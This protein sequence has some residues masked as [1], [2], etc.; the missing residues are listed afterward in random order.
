MEYYIVSLDDGN[1]CLDIENNSTKSKA[2]II[3]TN[4]H[5]GQS[6]KWRIQGDLIFSVHSGLVLDIKHGEDCYREI[7]QYGAHSRSNQLWRF[8]DDRS[9][10]SPKGYCID[11]EDGK[12]VRS[13][14]YYG[15]KK[16]KWS[17]VRCDQLDKRNLNVNIFQ[18]IVN[19]SDYRMLSIQ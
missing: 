1:K 13:A 17:L 4:F 10:R 8:D 12:Y 16:Q 3:V 19:N 5:G 15:L 18:I 9:I 14:N 2:R 7:I 6:Q 11:I